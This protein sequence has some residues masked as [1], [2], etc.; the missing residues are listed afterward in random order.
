MNGV[1]VAAG[2]FATGGTHAGHAGTN[3]GA[4]ATEVPAIFVDFVKEVLGAG[5]VGTD[6]HDVAGLTVE[7]LQAGA[8][9]FPAVPELAEHVG[10]VVVAGW[11]L[12]AEGVEFF[13][14]GEGLGHFGEAGD[15]A[16]AVTEY[17]NGATFPVALA[18][19][20]GV[21]QLTQKRVGDFPNALFRMFVAQTLD[22]GDEAGP[23]A[24]FQFVEHRSFMDLLC[25]VVLL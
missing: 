19:L 7:G 9:F 13:G 4:G 21:F 8:V 24:V 6:E 2:L 5:G 22:A 23:R 11:R 14:F 1:L 20:V 25:H 3:A 12:N 16:A 17:R 10:G 15:D 18:G